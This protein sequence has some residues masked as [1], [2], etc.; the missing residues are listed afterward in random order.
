MDL[1]DICMLGLNYL[2]LYA[3]VCEI[4]HPAVLIVLLHRI[5][6]FICLVFVLF[7]PVGRC[8]LP[9]QL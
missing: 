5:E 7:L 9:G 4:A 6:M 2:H 8:C 1:E 3:A